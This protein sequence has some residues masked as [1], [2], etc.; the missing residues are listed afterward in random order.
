MELT[1]K[2]KE[3]QKIIAKEVIKAVDLLTT[4]LEKFCENTKGTSVP[5]IY[6]KESVKIFKENYEKATQ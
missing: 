6:I 5:I 4:H 1:E 3:A 2:E